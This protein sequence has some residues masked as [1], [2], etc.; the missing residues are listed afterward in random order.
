MEKIWHKLKEKI[1]LMPAKPGVYLMKDADNSVIYVGKALSIKNR[2]K[3]Y[4]VGVD[5][6]AK[7]NLDPKTNLLVRKIFDIDYIITNTELEALLLETN[8]I[9]K[10][11]PKFNIMLRD[12]KS[13]PFIKITLTEEFPRL[14]ITRDFVNDGSKY[15]GPYTD[16]HAM[17][18]TVKSIRKLFNLR[19][20]SLDIKSE[21]II[22]KKPCM[23][24]QMRSCS[25]PCIGVI[26]GN[27][28]RDMV[29][30]IIDFLNGNNSQVVTSLKVLMNKL[31]SE[32]K[33]EEAAKVRDKL[34]YIYKTRQSQNIF[35]SDRKNRDVIGIYKEENYACVS[36]LKIF[37]GQMLNKETYHFSNIMNHSETELMAAFLK[38]YYH[39]K[40]NCLPYQII[41]Q[42]EPSEF[43]ELQCLFRSRLLVP[44]RGEN[45]KLVLIAKKNAFD[46]VESLMLSHFRKANR[47]IYP[48]QELK[49]KLKLSSLP[50]RIVCLDVST[51]QGTDTVSSLVFFENGKPLKKNYRHFTIK[52]IEGQDDFA[53]MRETMTRYLGK[54]DKSEQPDLII[55]DGGKGQL[56][57]AL[58]VLEIFNKTDIKIISLAK[59]YEEI[60][61]PGMKSPVMLPRSSS[62]LKLLVRIRDEA[63]NFAI[64]FHKK[65]RESRLLNSELDKLKGIGKDKKFLLLNRFGSVENIRNSSI[66][67]ISQVKGIGL[68]TA[69]TIL[70]GLMKKKC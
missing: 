53:G 69:Q 43:E 18:Q 65:K 5:N 35:F 57:S 7:S 25:A 22:K 60:Y 4:F 48:I 8:L 30:N 52:S 19:R 34:D 23:Y 38:Q 26:S 1:K 27:D 14:L 44:K 68:K 37:R 66:E 15:F 12:D 33:F 59:K 46:N 10:Y 50:R 67:E 47:T 64:K 61:L 45:L 17:R 29:Q 62:S 24:Y 28:Y 2:V 32:L 58:S 54:L 6:S 42:I 63:H 13:H 40:I 3:Q 55:I 11:R 21:D 16:V 56:N 70:T 39:E 9:K 31:S 36:V 49:E 41:L 51:I 20:C